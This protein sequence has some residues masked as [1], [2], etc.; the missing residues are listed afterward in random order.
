MPDS[1]AEV[2]K[3]ITKESIFTALMRLLEKYQF[4]EITITQI[5]SLA[6]VSRMAFYRNYNVK[7][8]IIRIYLD[9]LFVEFYDQIISLGLNSKYDI[10]I[11]F[12]S[13]FK[14]RKQFIEILIK[15]GLIHIFYEKLS[16]SL[17]NYFKNI[18][19]K[20]KPEYG[21]YLSHF[22]AGGLY[23]ILLEWISTDTKE[24]AEA[25]ASLVD[26]FTR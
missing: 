13:F 19:S 16:L 9:D 6:G 12:F 23:S 5:S 20:N 26:E 3:K 14:E 10:L 22:E 4:N 7:E 11:N 24:S 2:Q 15:S 1:Y 21:T 8:D 18:E 17:F 25:M